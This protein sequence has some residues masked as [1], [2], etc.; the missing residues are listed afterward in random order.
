[1]VYKL[2]DK[3]AKEMVLCGRGKLRD[4]VTHRKVETPQEWLDLVEE[5]SPQEKTS[6]EWTQTLEELQ[7]LYVEKFGKQLSIRYKNDAEWIKSKL[8]S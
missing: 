5:N 6:D 1:M 7:N 2:A 8:Y 3:E 4:N